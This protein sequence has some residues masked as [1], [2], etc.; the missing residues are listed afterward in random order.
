MY[1]AEMQDDGIR[2]KFFQPQVAALANCYNLAKQEQIGEKDEYLLT[3]FDF[4]IWCEHSAY[5]GGHTR[6]EFPENLMRDGCEPW[7]KWSS[8]ELKST[9]QSWCIIEFLK[10]TISIGS[11]MLMKAES[12]PP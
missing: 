8:G 11:F 4:N 7:N 5:N 1:R 10:E 3:D 9:K 12:N 6:R 2:L